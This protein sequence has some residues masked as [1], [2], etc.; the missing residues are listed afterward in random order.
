MADGFLTV[1][2]TEGVLALYKG[3]VPTLVGIAPY[4]GGFGVCHAGN[5]GMECGKLERGTYIC[6]M[7]GRCSAGFVLKPVALPFCPQPSTLRRT[8]C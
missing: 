8:T 7:P 4:A 5:A 3:L 6:N 2:R 1:L